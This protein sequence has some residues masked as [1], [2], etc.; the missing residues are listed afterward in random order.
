M[1]ISARWWALVSHI[2]GPSALAAATNSDIDSMDPPTALALKA[3]ADGTVVLPI[4]IKLHKVGFAD[5]IT[6][7]G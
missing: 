2:V 6:K 5:H 4:L 3:R 7:L 1:R